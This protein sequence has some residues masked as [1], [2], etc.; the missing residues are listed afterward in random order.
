MTDENSPVPKRERTF[1]KPKRQPDAFYVQ[2]KF[3]VKSSGFMLQHENKYKTMQE[4]YNML[5][6]LEN[7][8]GD[9]KLYAVY[10]R[11]GYWE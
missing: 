7:E 11:N 3:R 1:V 10:I 5:V 9:N 6:N 8:Y 4:V 2:V